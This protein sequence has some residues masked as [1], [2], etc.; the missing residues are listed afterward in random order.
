M[1]QLPQ[2][3]P[4]VVES[5]RPPSNWPSAGEV[6]IKNLTLKVTYSAALLMLLV[7]FCFFFKFGRFVAFVLFFICLFLSYLFL[8]RYQ[9]S[10]YRDSDFPERG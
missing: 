4:A 3:A 6:D 5:R 2:E 8:V 10:C 1:Y 9:V 7:F